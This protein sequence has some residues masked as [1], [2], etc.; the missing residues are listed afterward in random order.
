MKRR[1]FAQLPLLALFIAGGA[2]AGLTPDAVVQNMTEQVLAE[3][4]QLQGS[5]DPVRVRQ[6]VEGAILPNVDFASMTG[7]AIGVKWRSASDAQK[8]QLMTGF[9]SLLVKTYAGAFSQAQGAKFRLKGVRTVDGEAAEVRSEVSIRGGAEPI[10]INYRMA[11]SGS[12][13]KITDV[14]V[15]GIWLVSTYHSQFA[16]VL[17]NSE[18]DG[19]IRVLEEKARPR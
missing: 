16:Q 2:R 3:A 5:P 11:L 15:A 18:I 6:I 12:D 4:G 1:A 8:A 9:Q 13:W 17:Q 14:S 7:R 19:L 10:A